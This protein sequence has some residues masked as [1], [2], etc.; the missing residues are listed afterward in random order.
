MAVTST[1]SISV[2]ISGEGLNESNVFPAA[3]N[4]ASPANITYVS[5]VSGSNTITTTT[6]MVA[7][8]IIPPAGNT[9]SITFKGVSGDTG[10][11][12]HNT[13]P[14]SIGLDSTVSSFVLTAGAAITGVRIIW[15]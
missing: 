1:R 13:D 4:V 10:V 2:G 15:T 14:S 8:T 7:A 6:G 12:L 11:R 9:N 3:S 5:L